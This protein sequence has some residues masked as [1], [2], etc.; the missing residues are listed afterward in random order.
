MKNAKII[1]WGLIISISIA[2]LNGASLDADEIYTL[3]GLG[4]IGFGIWASII[5]LKNHEA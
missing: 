4:M 2:I 3:S 5:L 1:A